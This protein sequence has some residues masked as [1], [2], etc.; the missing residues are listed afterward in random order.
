MG[1]SVVALIVAGAL[2][3]AAPAS[4]DVRSH[5]DVIPCGVP[6]QVPPSKKVIPPNIDLVYGQY[7]NLYS[8]SG[9]MQ[10]EVTYEKDECSDA[11]PACWS[12]YFTLAWAS[13]NK[14]IGQ[15][16]QAIVYDPVDNTTRFIGPDHVHLYADEFALWQTSTEQPPFQVTTIDEDHHW[17]SQDDKPTMEHGVFTGTNAGQVQCQSGGDC[18]TSSSGCLTSGICAWTQDPQT[19]DFIDPAVTGHGGM[20]P[21]FLSNGGDIESTPWYNATDVE[22]IQT[23]PVMGRCVDCV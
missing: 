13:T 3:P 8:W 5:C 12:D 22:G 7:S 23:W 16:T 2:T 20:V 17:E 4:A 15:R 6:D 21:E 1:A 9:G 19:E 18:Y 11:P 10:V 14:V